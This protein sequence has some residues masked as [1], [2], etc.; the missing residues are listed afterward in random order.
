MYLIITPF[1]NEYVMSY[2]LQVTCMI[3]YV[4]GKITISYLFHVKCM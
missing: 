1:V 3:L 4:A 2:C